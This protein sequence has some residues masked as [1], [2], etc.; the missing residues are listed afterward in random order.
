MKK[1][2]SYDLGLDQKLVRLRKSK[3]LSQRELA[4]RLHLSSNTVSAYERAVKTPSAKILIELAYFYNTSLDYLVNLSHTRPIL[5]DGLT[6]EQINIINEIVE[7]FRTDNQ[8][9]HT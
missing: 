4:R 7:Q 2:P 1:D 8:S 5:T 6:E 3:N 9:G